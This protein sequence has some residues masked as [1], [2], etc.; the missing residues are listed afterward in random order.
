[1]SAV[2]VI[3]ASGSGERFGAK[4]LPKHLTEILE[5]PL[6]VWTI[7]TA[8][9]SGLFGSVMVVTRDEDI[10]ITQ[11]VT[12]Q[13]FFNSRVP[14]H[15]TVGADKRF[16][17]F[18]CGL[19]EAKNIGG[20]N[21]NTIVCLMDANRPFTPINQL[22]RMM[23]LARQGECSCPVRPVVNGVAR[24]KDGRI[25]EVPEKSNFVE[26]VTPECIRYETLNE[27]IKK[28]KEGF[29]SLVEYALALGYQPLTV[30]SSILN[31]KL[32]FPED[33]IYLEKL[34]LEHQ[35]VKPSFE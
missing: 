28:H 10:P 4:S 25:T 29:P 31:T 1:M 11:D 3:L 24:F 19:K 14:I 18:L 30:E 17:S 34:A 8:L 26:F 5:V 33:Q 12:N 15:V 22:E 32:T 23:D 13:Y 2:A 16:Q 21:P 35:L 27:S 20:V 6:L 9:K 7:D